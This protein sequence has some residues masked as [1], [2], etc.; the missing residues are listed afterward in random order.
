MQWGVPGRSIL[1]ASALAATPAAAADLSFR[2]TFEFDDDI[3]FIDFNVGALSTVTIRTLSYAGGINAAGEVIPRGGFDPGLALAHPSGDIISAGDDS[4]GVPEDPFTHQKFDVLMELELGAGAYRLAV[5]QYDNSA[6][7]PTFDDIF[8]RAGQGNFTPTMTF[9][10]ADRF[11]DVSGVLP[12]NARTG[13]WAVDVMNVQSA[14][15]VQ[16]P[17]PEPESWALLAAGLGLIGLRAR[18]RR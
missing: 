4:L 1:V 16:S 17:A 14:T 7:G 3:Q 11:C 18:T 12:W 2:G 5:T 8:T 10:E 13:N 9:C 6:L 15:L